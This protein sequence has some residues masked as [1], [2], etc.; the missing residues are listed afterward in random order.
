MIGARLYHVITDWQLFTRR[1]VRRRCTSGRAASASGARSHS[2]LPAP[3]VVARRRRM[4]V[5]AARR[6]DRAGAAAG[7]G[8]RAVGQLVQ[9]GAVRPADRPAVGAARSIRRTG[10]TATRQFETFH[11]TFL[12]ESLWNLGLCGALIFIA[13]D[14]A[15]GFGPDAVRM[16]VA[17]YTFARFFIEGLRID[18]A[19]VDLGPARE[20]MGR[21]G[22]VP[23]L[24][25]DPRRDELPRA[26][27]AWSSRTVEPDGEPDESSPEEQSASDEP[28]AEEAA[29][30]VASAHG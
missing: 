4:P 13:S 8:D 2:A 23:A 21:R 30:A 20:R 22:D 5:A 12:Y 6:C 24:G 17:G 7:P 9:P 11:P 10:P 19:N 15:T 16:Y 14:G 25:G 1:P 27:A 3:C 29:A 28:E 18:A 26:G